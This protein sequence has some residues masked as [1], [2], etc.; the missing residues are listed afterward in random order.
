MLRVLGVALEHDQQ[1]AAVVLDERADDLGE[2]RL[3]LRRR[4]A[5]HLLLGEPPPLLGR[6]G[7]LK[8]VAE[9]LHPR[10]GGQLG[11]VAG[12]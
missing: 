8:H 6:R 3:A 7:L 5:V 10:L 2:H 12:D 4:Q 1:L 9:Q 11:G